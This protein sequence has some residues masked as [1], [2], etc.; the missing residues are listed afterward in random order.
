MWWPCVM[1]LCDGPMCVHYV[2]SIHT[3]ISDHEKVKS[4]I[5]RKCLPIPPVSRQIFSDFPDWIAGNYFEFWGREDKIQFNSAWTP[6][7][8]D[9]DSWADPCVFQSRS[10]SSWLMSCTISEEPLPGPGPGS[11]ALSLT[12]L[13]S[14]YFLVAK[15]NFGFL[16]SLMTINWA[17]GSSL[18]YFSLRTCKLS[19]CSSLLVRAPMPKG[20]LDRD[21]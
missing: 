16:L 7:W 2:H 4:A 11:A 8:S 9:S 19:F 5:L 10:S 14:S 1:A 20:D 21:K 18:W 3:T 17:E 6:R 12:S 13:S 15:L